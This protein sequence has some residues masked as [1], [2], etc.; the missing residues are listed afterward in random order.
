M[1]SIIKRPIFLFLLIFTACAPAPIEAPLPTQTISPVLSASPTPFQPIA[2]TA[3][4]SPFPT[5]TATIEPTST[6]DPFSKYTIPA[7][8]ARGYGGGVI[9]IV[10]KLDDKS[11]FTRYKIRYP[12]DGL[13]IYGFVNIPK[14]EGPFPVIIA[15]HGNYDTSNYQLMPYSTLDADILARRGYIVFHPN[16]RN[17]G[18]SSK[19]DDLYRSG[20]AIDILNLVALIKAPVANADELKKA[21]TEKIGLWAHSMGGEI[22]LRVITVSNLIDATVLYAPMTGDI[23]KN[24]QMLN[25]AEELNTPPHLIPAISPHY[26]YYNITSALKLY[27]GTADSVI[28]VEYSRE[29]CQALTALGKEINCAFY[30]GAEH[31]FNGNY[32][33]DFEKSFFYF[34]KTHL[35]EP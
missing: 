27:H 10:E 28:P 6:P 8:R 12:S 22:A 33:T 5:P 2:E 7:M 35:L 34:F 9:E 19:G 21:K 11:K 14:G 32:T 13:T 26:S 1:N 29:T 25:Q 18:E 24:A 16:M 17:F 30:E 4:P 31:T 3:T 20:T 23:I 15:I